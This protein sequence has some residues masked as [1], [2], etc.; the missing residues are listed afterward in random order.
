VENQGHYVPGSD[1]ENVL[2]LRSPE[3]ANKIAEIGP[4]KK[5]VIIGSSFIGMELA[6]FLA[7]KA[8]C[9]TVI[10]RSEIPFANVLGKEIGL[11]LKKMH[12]DKGV[13]FIHGQTVKEFKGRGGKLSSVVLTDGNELEA[14][15]CL[16]GVGVKASTEFLA[17]SRVPLN[18]Q[19]SI[20]VNK[21]MEAS[22]SVYAAGDIA[23]FPLKMLDWES[24]TIGHWQMAHK[25]GL[26]A[27][28]NMMGKK[29]EINTVP[30]FWTMQYGKSVRYCG[31]AHQFDD[32]I[33]DGSLD[34]MKFIAYFVK[35]EKVLAVATMG[36]DP[37][38]A[39]AAN[40]LYEGTMPT[41]SEI[42]ANPAGWLS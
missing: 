5:A 23:C 7:G 16:L 42:R 4:G 31:H 11:L 18:S 38:A 3:D 22:D 35:G 30:F 36:R 19:G 34:D 25:H 17:N 33:I 13:K 12:E 10:G 39:K 6:A 24:V 37:V 1:L 28:R 14:D 15:L 2:L 8:T 32:V 21:F 29:E 41:A 40:H 20:I 9:V 27:A 26:T